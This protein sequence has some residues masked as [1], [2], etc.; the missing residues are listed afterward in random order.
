MTVLSRGGVYRNLL[1]SKHKAD[2][3]FRSSPL[4]GLPYTTESSTFNEK[5]GSQVMSYRDPYSQQPG[6]LQ[7]HN[8]H[9]NEATPDYNPYST[10]QPPH[11]TYDHEDIGPSYDGYG[12]AY[13]DE[14]QYDREYPPRRGPS[15]RTFAG[16]ATGNNPPLDSSASK[17]SGF[18][19][20][21][22]S[23]PPGEK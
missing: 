6:R 11:Q 19:T 16:G 4:T 9:Y 3:E 23:V 14:P 7:S 10:T 5:A 22:F 21:V 17:E 13:R 1:V 20:E 15:Q 2:Q 8:N 18:D 12:N